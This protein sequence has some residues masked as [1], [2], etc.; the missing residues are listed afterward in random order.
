MVKGHVVLNNQ[1]DDVEVGQNSAQVIE[2]CVV[3]LLLE[4]LFVE[5]CLL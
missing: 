4:A 3:I 1:I 2:D 5:N